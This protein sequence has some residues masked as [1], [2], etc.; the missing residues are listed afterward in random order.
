MSPFFIGF[1]YHRSTGGLAP[2]ETALPAAIR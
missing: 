1:G 2:A